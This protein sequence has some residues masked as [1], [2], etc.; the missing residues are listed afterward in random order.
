MLDNFLQQNSNTF[1]TFPAGILKV[2][3]LGLYNISLEIP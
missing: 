2:I 1:N 3:I